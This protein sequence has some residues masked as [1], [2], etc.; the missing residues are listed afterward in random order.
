MSDEEAPKLLRRAVLGGVWAVV[1]GTFVPRLGGLWRHADPLGKLLLKGQF[2]VLVLLRLGLRKVLPAKVLDP[3]AVVIPSVS[4]VALIGGAI[5]HRQGRH[6][7]VKTLLL[8][9]VAWGGIPVVNEGIEN[10]TKEIGDA[11]ARSPR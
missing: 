8:N 4:V 10:M 7:L 3:P 9:V 1:L 11:G 2:G 5:F 6:R